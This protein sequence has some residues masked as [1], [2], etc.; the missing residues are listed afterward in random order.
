LLS[1]GLAYP[2]IFLRKVCAYHSNLFI[3]VSSADSVCSLQWFSAL[4]APGLN[5]EEPRHSGQVHSTITSMKVSRMISGP[6]AGFNVQSCCCNGKN[7]RHKTAYPLRKRPQT[8]HTNGVAVHDA[9]KKQ[10]LRRHPKHKIEDSVSPSETTEEEEDEEEEE[11]EE[12]EEKEEEEE[13]EDSSEQT[14]KSFIELFPE[15]QQVK[16]L[17]SDAKKIQQQID[18]HNTSARKKWEG[19]ASQAK[20]WKQTRKQFALKFDLASYC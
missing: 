14:F 5:R 19:A 9:K 18:R 6:V 20:F 7:T 4:F 12:E 17:Q 3:S 1:F 13:E 16:R 8:V 2:K 11:E 10:K 15:N